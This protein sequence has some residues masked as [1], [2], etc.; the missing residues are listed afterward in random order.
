MGD[1]AVLWIDKEQLKLDLDVEFGNVSLAAD[2]LSLDP[3]KADSGIA[4][5]L[6]A[7]GGSTDHPPGGL[8]TAEGLTGSIDGAGN[9]HL[10]F[11]TLHADLSNVSSLDAINGSLTAGPDAGSAP[12]VA[13][14][15]CHTAHAAFGQSRRLYHRWAS[16]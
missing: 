1:P 8:A 9:M 11:A 4:V 12:L 14:E 13:V 5:V 7:P 3:D 15:Q 6:P 10:S 2:S 16:I